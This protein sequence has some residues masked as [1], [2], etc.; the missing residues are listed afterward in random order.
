VCHH[1]WQ[2]FNFLKHHH[3]QVQGLSRC[4]GVL[5]SSLTWFLGWQIHSTNY[6]RYGCWQHWLVRAGVCK[7]PGPKVTLP[8]LQWLGIKRTRPQTPCPILDYPEGLYSVAKVVGF[9]V[10]PSE[11]YQYS[12]FCCIEIDSGPGKVWTDKV[13]SA[14]VHSESLS[15]P[16]WLYQNYVLLGHLHHNG[17]GWQKSKVCG[18][19]AC[20]SCSNTSHGSF[21]VHL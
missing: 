14:S 3:F 15:P 9:E 2:E 20:I 1:T 17:N 6:W 4:C 8:S 13:T 11:S 16:W 18:R 10:A 5:F 7:Q 19:I 21:S 12:C